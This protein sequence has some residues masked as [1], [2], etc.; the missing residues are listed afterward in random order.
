MSVGISLGL[1]R[2][3]KMSK[4]APGPGW[5]NIGNAVWEHE[6]GTRI[7]VSGLVRKPDMTFVSLNKHPEGREGGRYIKI[8]GGNRKRGLMTWAVNV[9]I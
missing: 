7:H 9:V 5:A 6:N 4:H 3:V 1:I 2:E 8:N